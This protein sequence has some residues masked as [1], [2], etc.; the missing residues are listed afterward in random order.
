[1]RRREAEWALDVE[2][3]ESVGSGYSSETK[4]E[5]FGGE[6]WDLSA[7]GRGLRKF[8]GCRQAR[9]FLSPLRLTCR[10]FCGPCNGG[11]IGRELRRRFRRGPAREQFPRNRCARTTSRSRSSSSEPEEAAEGCEIVLAFEFAGGLGHGGFVKRARI[12]ERA[13]I[14]EWRQYLTAIDAVAVGFSLAPASERGNRGPL[15]RRRRC[16][17][18]AEVARS[19]RAEIRRPRARIAF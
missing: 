10:R 3:S 15:L 12:V 1:M 9:V 11:M 17:S 4:Y 16:G 5:A 14:F 2:A 18:R 19:S 8:G 7:S 6:L 13:S